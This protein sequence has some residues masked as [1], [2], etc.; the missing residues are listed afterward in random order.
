MTFAAMIRVKNEAR[1]IARVIES[2]LPVTE[3]IFILDDHSTD[4]TRE[5]C[6]GYPNVRVFDSPFEGL[7]ESRDKNALLKYVRACGPY[8]WV[9]HIDGDE[10]L[11]P[12]AKD[13]ILGAIQQ[14]RMAAVFRFQVCY[15]WDREG[16]WRTDG[17]YGRFWRPSMFRMGARTDLKFGT[18]RHGGNLHC[19][20][21]PVNIAGGIDRAPVR[22]LHYGYFDTEMR[23]RKYRFYNSVD[24]DNSVEDCYRHVVI[25]DLFPAESRFRHA[26]PL[27]LEPFTI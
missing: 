24:P 1:W 27:K 3:S 26:G 11:E 13:K 12:G 20:N 2:I 25:G 16:Q 23:V 4:A 21:Y 19:S 22:L 17:I 5:I 14:R 15:L 10:V 18:T 6:R 9:L 8:D 7:D